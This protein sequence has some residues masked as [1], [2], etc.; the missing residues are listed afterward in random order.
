MTENKRIIKFRGKAVNW[1]YGSL[2]RAPDGVFIIEEGISM[3]FR[4]P[5]YHKAGMGCGLEDR[6]ITDRYE[7]MEYGF[8][9]AVQ[10]C[11]RNYPVIIEVDPETVGQFI[12]LLDKN[13]KEIYE[14]DIVR[15]GWHEDEVGVVEFS[16]G[17]FGLG[18]GYLETMSTQVEDC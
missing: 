9:D 14:G 6:G 3:R 12:G 18:F 7:A 13:R 1:V 2:V 5:E 4:E 15:N 8:Q 16:Y 10:S 11:E 17:S